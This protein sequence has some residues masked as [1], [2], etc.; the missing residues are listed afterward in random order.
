MAA[1]A[2]ASM[3]SMHCQAHRCH[4]SNPG[5][6]SSRTPPFP[7][8]VPCPR[9]LQLQSGMWHCLQ[10][11]GGDPRSPTSEP[12]WSPGASD[13]GT[14]SS[15]EAPKGANGVEGASTSSSPV[16]ALLRS[17]FVLCACILCQAFAQSLLVIAIHLSCVQHFAMASG[18]AI[19]AWL[20]GVFLSILQAG[21]C[22]GCC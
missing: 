7:S 2:A 16:S 4:C 13:G 3:L 18:S 1:Q 17:P 14:S 20:H 21:P 6:F 22:P 5:A 8:L 10:G 15:Q 19:A 11:L 12:A 9:S